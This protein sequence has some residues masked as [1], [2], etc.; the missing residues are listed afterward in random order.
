MNKDTDSLG[1]RL[2]QRAAEM[3]PE[4]A[5]QWIELINLDDYRTSFRVAILKAIDALNSSETKERP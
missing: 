2:S 5:I 1:V 4:E 3:P